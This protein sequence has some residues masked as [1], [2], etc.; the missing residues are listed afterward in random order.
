MPEPVAVVPGEEALEVVVTA[1][2]DVGDDVKRY[3]RQRVGHMA[4]TVG[5]PVLF[6]GVNLAVEHDPARQRPA[7]ARAVLDVNGDLVRVHVSAH[8]LPEAV[9]LLEQRLRA[10]LEHRRSRLEAFR[11]F[12]ELPV[13]GEWRH[14]EPPSAGRPRVEEQEEVERRVVPQKVFIEDPMTVDEAVYDMEQ[15]GNAFGLFCDLATGLDSVVERAGPEV[16]RLTR[17]EPVDADLGPTAVTVEVSATPVPALAL[18]DAVERLEAGG[19]PFVFFADPANGRGR[20]LYHRVDGNY[21]LLV[22]EEPVPSP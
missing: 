17:V 15:L 16:Y 4:S 9:D 11:R 22:P 20:V 6:A 3:A 2:D 12:R 10:R 1:A 19:E 21:G 7:T 5:E 14:G 13:E 8:N 18:A